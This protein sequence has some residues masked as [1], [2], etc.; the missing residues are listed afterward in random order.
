MSAPKQ[1]IGLTSAEVA[2]KHQAGESNFVPQKTSRSL[3]EILRSNIFTVFNAILTTAVV[4]VLLIGD[5]RDAIFG[6]VMVINAA[7]GI[8]SELRSKRTLD[9][10]AVLDAPHAL[11][12]RDGKQV[13]IATGD[14]VTGDAVALQ[15]GDQ[16]PADGVVSSSNGLET[17][18]SALSGESQPVRKSPG[19]KILSG[20]AVVAGSGVMTVTAVGA[21]AWAQKVTAAAKKYTKVHSEIEDSINKILRMITWALPVVMVLL[22]WSQFRVEH[23]EWRPAVVLAIAGVVG[24]IPQG[25]V[26]LTSMNFGIAAATLARRGVLVQ[27][28]PAVEV[29]ARVDRLCLDKTGTIT[30]GGITGTDLYG[31]P[32]PDPHDVEALGWLSSDR[33]NA[34]AQAVY[35]LV[36]KQSGTDKLSQVPAGYQTIPFSSA[37]KWAAIFNSSDGTWVMGAPDVVLEHAEDSSWATQIVAKS[38]GGGRRTVTLAWSP[39][40]PPDA[41]SLPA[42]L[43]ARLV[44]VLQEEIRPDAEATLKYFRDQDVS[45][46]IISGDAPATVAFIADKVNLIGQR[47]TPLKA[48][49]ARELP[50]IDS[51]EFPKAVADVDVFGRVSP[52]QK[53]ALVTVY[54]DL[55]HTVAMTGDGVNDAMALKQADL[56]IA[57]GN[58]ARATKAASRLVL[59]NG[60]FS[61]LP[62]VVAEGRRIMANMERVSS[63]FLSK[64]T[65]SLLLAVIVSVFAFAFPFLPRHL[66]Y[67]GWF[68]IGIPAFIIAL[69]PNKRRYVPGFLRRTLLIAVPSGVIMG[70]CALAA[71]LIVGRDSVPGQSAATLTIIIGGLYLLSV[72]ARPLNL[73]RVALIATMAIAA[74]LGVFAV[75]VR[76]FFA[77]QWPN[78]GQWVTILIAGTISCLLIQIGTVLTRPYRDRAASG[79]TSSGKK[80]K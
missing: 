78:G 1:T 23:H 25:L 44:A 35:S 19:D 80:K 51:S 57:M 41:E 39:Q 64:T 17:D 30:T 76:H 53:K 63:L 16:V 52:E 2:A 66:T 14:I 32:K 62:G 9:S 75:P 27:E 42:G 6:L 24:M 8:F 47:P 56:G 11:V 4:I 60:E 43:S 28:L 26:L 70:L 34:T 72:T 20:T 15:M 48:V 31:N 58:A 45:L 40:V 74:A 5:Y 10:A 37:R 65:Y 77:L 55:G 46:R 67:I 69:G 29:L 13:E 54:Q 71:Y 49:D 7:I 3:G 21:N 68:T 33:V 73:G 18:E 38:S 50:P 36:Q 61:V 59:M 12:W 79:L 22:V